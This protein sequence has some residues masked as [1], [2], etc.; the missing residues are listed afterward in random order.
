M[1]KHIHFIGICGVGMSAIAIALHKFGYRVTGSDKGFYPPVSTSLEQAGVPFYAGFHPDQMGTP[2]MVVVGTAAGTQ[3]PELIKARELNIPV[4]SYPEVLAEYFVKSNSIVTTGTWGKTTS[5]ALLAHILKMLGKAP[6]YMI[7]GVP[8]GMEPAELV[9]SDWSVLEGDEYKSAPWDTRP[10]FAH[11]SPTHLLLS[12]VAWD[13]MDVYPAE[14][15]YFNAFEN[16]V[17]SIPENGLIVACKDNPGVHRVLPKAK[18]RVVTY[19]KR[20]TN[21]YHF[22]KIAQSAKGLRFGIVRE[23]DAYAVDSPLLGDFQAENITGCFALAREIGLPP[24]EILLAIASF[25]GIKR[26]LEKRFESEQVTV[27]DDIAHSP[28]KARATLRTLRAIYPNH[29][30]V[31][32]FEPNIGSRTP[33]SSIKST[34]AFSSADT[35]IIPQLTKLKVDPKATVKPLEGRDL[36]S[37]IARGHSNVSYIPGDEKLVTELSV[38]D[39]QPRVIVFLGSHSFRQMIKQLCEKLSH[40]PSSAIT[41]SS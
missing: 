4:K 15:L 18:A 26:R 7:G 41:A 11:S 31:A 21:D 24:K 37:L 14:D 16:L 40:L 38:A 13:H 33:E 22:V 32:V 6:S 23:R 29:K 30:I 10:K 34:D 25:K 39:S 17:A 5:S 12:G 8:I 9:D 3:N 19:G 20:K 1:Q 2:D 36:A 27:I 35:V 28:D